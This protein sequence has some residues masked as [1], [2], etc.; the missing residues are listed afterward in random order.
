MIFDIQIVQ[1]LCLI[2]AISIVSI[3]MG[4]I[5]KDISYRQERIQSKMLISYLEERL[6]SYSVLDTSEM[7]RKIIIQVVTDVAI[8]N[9]HEFKDSHDMQKVTRANV[10]DLVEKVARDSR[11]MFDI[12]KIKEYDNILGKGSCD[13]YIVCMSSTLVKNILEKEVI[14]IIKEEG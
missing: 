7:I 10:R 13:K 14:T 6:K 5:I 1:D 3:I 9:F 11:A 2:F 4:M 8:M 12:D